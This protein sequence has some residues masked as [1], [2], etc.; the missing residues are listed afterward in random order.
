MS[1]AV[2][3]SLAGRSDHQAK[4]NKSRPSPAAPAS[5]ALRM[6]GSANEAMAALP[7][8]RGAG[9]CAA[10]GSSV[11]GRALAALLGCSVGVN[12]DVAVGVSVDV[13]VGVS[14]G[15][16][17]G[18]CGPAF[19]PVG[20]SVDFA[21]ALPAKPMLAPEAAVAAPLDGLIPDPLVYCPIGWVAASSLALALAVAVGVRGRGSTSVKSRSRSNPL[22]ASTGV[23]GCAPSI[24]CRALTMASE[25][26][27]A[28]T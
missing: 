11:A 17:A 1:M 9:G 20:A 26:A 14:V 7:G 23:G 3:G 25:K 16:G 12:A 6:A 24:G 2:A 27:A 19:D 22:S 21:V 5:L 8:C 10:G 28:V 4:P 15:T 18:G 13:A